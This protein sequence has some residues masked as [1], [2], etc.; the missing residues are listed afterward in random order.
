MDEE[1][2]YTFGV[3]ETIHSYNGKYFIAKRFREVIQEFHIRHVRTAVYSPQSNG[4]ERVN[5]LVLYAIRAY[6][7][8]DYGN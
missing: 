8:Q 2:V 7:D 6:M 5:Q 3:P 1:V 4:A